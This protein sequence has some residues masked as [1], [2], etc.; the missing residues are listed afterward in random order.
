MNNYLGNFG[1]KDDPFRITPDPEYYYPTQ[2]HMVALNSLNYAME[3]REGFCLLTGE[4]GTGKTTLLKVFMENWK[5][6]AEIALIMTPRLSPDEFI[7]ALLEDFNIDN[8]KECLPNNVNLSDKNRM[9]KAFRK[10]LLGHSV[11]GRRVAIIVDEAQNLP[12]ET[13][14]ELRLLSNLE[15]YKEKLIQIILVGQPELH[16]KIGSEQL[17]QL[18]QRVTVSCSLLSLSADETVDYMNARLIKAGAS[19]A[20]LNKNARSAIHKLSGG[21]P[22]MINIIAARA[23][24]AAYLKGSP[25]VQR[26]HVLIGNTD[27][28]AAGW[29]Q[30]VYTWSGFTSQLLFLLILVILLA[31]IYS[32]GM[33][34]R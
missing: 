30:R 19:A 26:E 10:F 11:E 31:S 16:H 25:I 12:V 23:I 1:L 22:R 28:Q 27:G 17:K 32:A 24:M 33:L 8:H 29:A 5:D 6:R 13:L 14:E 18:A 4:P 20:V 2:E 3:Q 7:E 9:L 34:Q 15:T 21:I